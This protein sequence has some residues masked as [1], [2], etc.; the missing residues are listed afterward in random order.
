M[1]PSE[2]LGLHT[3]LVAGACARASGVVAG[4]GESDGAHNTSNVPLDAGEPFAS[5]VRTSVDLAVP[6]VFGP[7][8]VDWI[9]A[10][11]PIAVT[12]GEYS[13]DDGPFTSA[14]DMVAYGQHVRIRV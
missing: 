4:C 13:I 7:F 3:A 5:S 6:I 12:G 1:S 8:T 10:P 14:S 11:S 2:H 9:G